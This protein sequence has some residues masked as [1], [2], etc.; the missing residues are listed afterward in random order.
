MNARLCLNPATTMPT[1]FEADVEAYAAAGFRYTELWLAK[2]KDYLKTHDLEDAR[3]VLDRAGIEAAAACAFSGLA[4]V[5]GEARKPLLEDYAQTLRICQALGAPVLI[6]LAGPRPEEITDDLWARSVA[7]LREAADLAQPIVLAFEFLK[8]APYLNNLEAAVK[9]V[10]EVDR[11]NVGVLFDTFH[12][13]AGMSQMPDLDLLTKQNLA[14][15]HVNDARPM[16]RERMTDADR[17]PLGEGCFPLKEILGKVAATGYDRPYSLELFNRAIWEE[18]P[19]AVA[20]RCRKNMEA[21][22]AGL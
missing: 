22:F 15:V 13:Y 20:R 6:A 4:L 14:F 2:V 5:S 9:L 21:F 12:F 8:G 11:P 3:R 7:H 18:D 19:A 10:T 17:V 1:P 16:L